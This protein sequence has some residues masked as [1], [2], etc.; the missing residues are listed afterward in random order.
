MKNGTLIAKTGVH[1]P[2]GRNR[3]NA[4]KGG[5]LVI[6]TLPS[7]NVFLRSE[8]IPAS[9]S[10]KNGPWEIGST[11][12]VFL[13]LFS[14]PRIRPRHPN[15]SL[16]VASASLFCLSRPGVWLPAAYLS[17]VPSESKRGHRKTL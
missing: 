3:I 5:Y 14:E 4:G 10:S 17:P 9:P 15:E 13:Q 2:E 7:S 16:R 12:R 6:T 1:T 8:S 11:Q